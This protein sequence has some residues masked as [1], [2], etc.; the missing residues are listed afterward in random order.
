MADYCSTSDIKVDMPDS[1]LASSTDAT[2]DTAIGNMITAAS[3]LIDK[4]IGREA[5][6]FSTTDEETRY[7]DGS[8]EVIQEIDELHTLTSVSISDVGGTSSTSYEAITLDTDFYV[9]PYQYDQLGVP[10]T[11]LIMDWNGDEY[12]WPHFRKAVKVVGQFGYSATPP[13]DVKMACKI[14]TMRWFG[15]SKQMW[16]DAGGGS[17]TGQLVY[18][19]VAKDLDPDVRILLESYVI[20]NMV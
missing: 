4:Y 6:W 11:R 3:R 16:Q 18:S 20:G 13:E 12:T 8:G 9:W 2:Y 19:R 7:F 15:R 14:Q 10:I 17:V 5:N 1:G